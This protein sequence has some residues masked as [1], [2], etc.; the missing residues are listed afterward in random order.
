MMNARDF[1][2]FFSSST[3][4]FGYTYFVDVET[5]RIYLEYN[6]YC[7]AQ[8]VH[9]YSLKKDKGVWLFTEKDQVRTGMGD[10]VPNSDTKVAGTDIETAIKFMAEKIL[11]KPARHE[12]AKVDVADLEVKLWAVLRDLRKK[13]WLA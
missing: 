13:I 6:I 4:W 10:G 5:G 7:D 8:Y 11:E 1:G 9:C 12:K 3:E 2:R